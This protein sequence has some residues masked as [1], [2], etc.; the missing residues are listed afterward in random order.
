MDEEIDQEMVQKMM[1]QQMMGQKPPTFTVEIT[2]ID[3]VTEEELL[4][5]FEKVAFI[6]LKEGFVMIMFEDSSSKMFR[7]DNVIGIDSKINVEE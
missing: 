4:V 3:P 7:Q 6:D 5:C 1:E 2:V